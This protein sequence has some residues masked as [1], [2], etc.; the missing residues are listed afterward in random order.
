MK[1]KRAGSGSARDVCKSSTLSWERGKLCMQNFYVFTKLTIKL[2]NL[3]NFLH[4]MS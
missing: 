3:T 1:W 4:I 2:N